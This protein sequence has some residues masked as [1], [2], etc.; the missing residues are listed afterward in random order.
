ML[1]IGLLAVDWA[2][3]SSR[4]LTDSIGR[5]AV[6]GAIIGAFTAY[7][8]V[9]VG[10]DD[11][12]L[13]VRNPFLITRVPLSLVDT[14]D[15]RLGLYLRIKD[16]KLAVRVGAATGLIRFRQNR[17]INFAQEIQA[18]VDEAGEPVPGQA[19]KA[20]VKVTWLLALP[21]GVGLFILVDLLSHALR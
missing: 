13:V 2:N 3:G 5:A 19:V 20:R 11:S 10:V 1:L 17:P 7:A 6:L 8:D 14:V 9:A 16:Q 12:T 21:A 4:L 15:A 18:L